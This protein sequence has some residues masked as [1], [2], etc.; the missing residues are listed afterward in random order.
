MNK[1]NTFIAIIVNYNSASLTKKFIESCIEMIPNIAKI[2][3]VDNKSTKEDLD[4]IKRMRDR[5]SKIVE[6]IKNNENL[7]YFEGLNTG[8]RFYKENF[9][10]DNNY[11][12]IGN[13]DVTFDH[14]FAK[15][16]SNLKKEILEYPVIS[17]RI[18][19]QSGIEQ[20]PHVIKK[21]S[22]FREIIYDFYYASYL[23]SMIIKAIA[24]LTHSLSDRPDEKQ[25]S[26]SQEIYQGYG[27]FYI[28]T[29]AFFQYFSLLECPVKLHYEEFFLAKMLNEKGF[30][31]WY[32]SSLR[33][34]H[35]WHGSFSKIQSKQKWLHA[36]TAHKEYR[37]HIK[38]LF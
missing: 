3:V 32:E 34:Y 1:K 29:P 25:F 5:F 27:A 4:K 16:F 38:G 6:V 8:I 19:T 26:V 24:F 10:S 28:L 2:I 13:N 30:H 31:V 15:N 36:K 9:F 35:L 7:G 17:P 14:S 11:L 33:I 18:T 23:F 37:K 21:I 22:R 20:N 12:L